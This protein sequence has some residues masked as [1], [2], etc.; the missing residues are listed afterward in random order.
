MELAFITGASQGYGRQLAVEFAKRKKSQNV[1][2]TLVLSARSE[3]NLKVTQKLVHEVDDKASCESF[4]ID[5]SKLDNLEE[6]LLS[7]LSKASNYHNL[8]ISMMLQNSNESIFSIMPEDL[9]K[10]GK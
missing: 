9:V 8:T 5:Y 4:V 2:T 10:L 7:V 3:E 6:K 1:P